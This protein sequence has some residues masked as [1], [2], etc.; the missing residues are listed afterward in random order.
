MQSDHSN[1]DKDSN[2]PS[3]MSLMT[4]LA[5]GPSSRSQSQQ[6]QGHEDQVPDVTLSPPVDSTTLPRSVGAVIALVGIFS[7][8]AFTPH[9]STK[10][11]LDLAVR[12]YDIFVILMLE[13]KSARAKLTILQFMMRIR[14]DR[15]HRIYFVDAA[16]DPDGCFSML[17]SLIDRGVGVK[18]GQREDPVSDSD[19]LRKARARL[20][21]ERDGRR[22]SR[23]RGARVSDSAPSRSRSRVTQHPFRA[24]PPLA[25][26]PRDP[27][28]H[29]PDSLPFI[30]S[31]ADTPSDGLMSY[32]PIRGEHE[33]VLQLSDYLEAI[34]TILDKEKNWEIL[35]Y[36]LCHLPVQLANKHL[37]CG[38]KCREIFSKLL[39]TLC[40]GLISG[41]LAGEVDRWPYGLKVRDAH[42]LA[43]HTISVL[44]SY[45]RCF[46]GR[47]Q[48]LLVE[49]LQAGLDGQPSTIKCCLHG[50]SLAAFE[51]QSSMKKYLTV[52][53]EKLSQIMS[54]PEMAVHILSFLAFV[55]SL[56]ELHYNFTDDDFKMVFGVA[57]QYLQHYNRP[58]SPTTSWA[59]SQHLRILAYYIVYTWF[60][61]VK[62]SDRPHHIPYITRQL[63]LVNEGRAEVDEPTEVCFDWLARYTYASADP[64]PTNSLLGEI[65]MNPTTPGLSEVAIAE[66]TWL[67]G[68]SFVTIR[69]LARLGWIEIL[70]R[71]PSGY[72]KFLCRV[73]NVPMVGAGDVD[74][75]MTSVPASL[76]MDRDPP[77]VEAP[78]GHE[79]TNEMIKKTTTANQLEV[80]D[81]PSWL[82][83]AFD[84]QY[85]RIRRGIFSG[86]M[87]DRRTYR[88]SPILSRVMFGVAQHPPSVA[89]MLRLIHHSALCTSRPIP[90]LV[91][92]GTA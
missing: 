25:A 77:H 13:G 65:V 47:Q 17:S 39:T 54:N 76:L 18:E 53:L 16:Y 33:H 88:R 71:R 82:S 19:F 63:L 7:Q 61:A 90:T 36:V 3:V 67:V 21:Q 45:R 6:P 37:F 20:P 43:Y 52:I 74:P 79:P 22:T 68:N 12:I 64:R 58:E 91:P 27:I 80:S 31:D 40:A 8:L 81:L 72:T 85:S 73:E 28:W 2:M 14:A 87:T 48:H 4:S 62:L 70:S 10:Q 38:P 83:I 30:V 89:N 66:K 1:K 34:L 84:T 11:N 32:D 92:W 51:L 35:S 9:A 60:L 78:P 86:L 56:R 44:I 5:T 15:D 69:A 46:D 75:D 50:L 29:V 49:V 41:E 59:L 24:V 23:G 57:L 26:K 55:G 42:G